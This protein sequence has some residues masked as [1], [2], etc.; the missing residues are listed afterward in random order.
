MIRILSFNALIKVEFF[1]IMN[2][3]RTRDMRKKG[4][5][6]DK[7][8]CFIKLTSNNTFINTFLLIE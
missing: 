7:L 5:K 8:E 1:F 6:A 2:I 3:N 4:H